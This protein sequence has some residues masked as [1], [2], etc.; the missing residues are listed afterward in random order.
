MAGNEADSW[1]RPNA[2][3]RAAIGCGSAMLKCRS[4]CA[5]PAAAAPCSAPSSPRRGAQSA[6]RAADVHRPLDPAPAR[7]E[8]GSSMAGNEADSRPRPN[9]VHR[10]A[11]GCGSAMLKCRSRCADPA[12]AA[13]CSAPSSPRRGAP[14]A[15]RAAGVRRPLDPAPTRLPGGRPRAPRV[16][17]QLRRWERESTLTA[18]CCSASTLGARSTDP[19]LSIVRI[20][21]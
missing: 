8:R 9:A 17:A 3:H 4:R 15:A 11:I 2:V 10:A 5:D 16:A 20:R 7:R 14:S 12:T 13:P 1:P 6:A 18:C 19:S 21:P